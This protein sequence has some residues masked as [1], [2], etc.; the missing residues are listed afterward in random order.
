MLPPIVLLLL[1]SLVVWAVAL[2]RWQQGLTVIPWSPRRPVG[3]SGWELLAIAFFHVSLGV[4][5]QGAL[6]P[7]LTTLFS[8]G[9]TSPADVQAPTGPPDHQITR[10]LRSNP[11]VGTWLL[12]AF[13]AVLV[14]PLLEEF[15]FRVLLQ[16]WLEKKERSSRAGFGPFRR[17]TRGALPVLLSALPFALLHWRSDKRILQPNE[18]LALL[19]IS[20]VTNLATVVAAVLFLR[21]LGSATWRDMGIDFRRV[22]LDFALA[23]LGVFAVLGPAYAVLLSV[24]P[25]MPAG[26]APDPVP[27]FLLALALGYIYYRTHRLLPIFV[28]H[29]LFNGFAVLSLWLAE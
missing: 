19:T 1:A 26:I 29:A 4:V 10:L 17:W 12:C 15:L 11:G 23:V 20:T 25:L 5:L 6:A 2:V 16:G 18:L 24:R 7:S 14:A 8:G 22:G 13:S 3:W 27:L 28:L 21:G 9:D